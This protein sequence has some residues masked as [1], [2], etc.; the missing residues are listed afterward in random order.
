LGK[1]EVIRRD[2][3]GRVGM[4]GRQG[5]GIMIDVLRGGGEMGE[6]RGDGRGV[7]E[8]WVKRDRERLVTVRVRYINGGSS[9]NGVNR[10]GQER[11]NGGLCWAG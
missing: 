11:K 10:V 9:R 8:E 3:R 1:R 7:E 5:E 6:K 4:E 2:S